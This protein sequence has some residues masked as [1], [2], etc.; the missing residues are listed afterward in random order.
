MATTIVIQDMVSG[1]RC[2]NGRGMLTIVTVTK[3]VVAENPERTTLVLEVATG[4]RRPVASGEARNH[5]VS[6]RVGCY[7]PKQRATEDG[8]ST[9]H[10]ST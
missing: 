7:L 9:A 3:A 5:R 4:I 8:R 6:R 10:S 2:P 1:S